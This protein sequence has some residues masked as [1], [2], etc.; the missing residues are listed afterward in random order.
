MSLHYERDSPEGESE[1]VEAADR[2]VLVHGFAQT[3]RCWGAV[4]DN[5]ADDHELVR[6][7]APGHGG[8]GGI[9]VDLNEGARLIAEVGGQA[10]YLGYSMGARFALHVAL[11]HPEIVS[12]LVL[13]GGTPGIEDDAERSLRHERDLA[14]AARIRKAGVDA[15]L[16]TWFDQPLFATLP[17][18]GRFLDERRRN[19]AEGLAR[20]LELAG[21][22]SQQ[23]LWQELPGL[24]MPVLVVTGELD[25]RYS[26]IAERM[27]GEI[28]DNA[29]TRIIPGAGHAAHLE[30]P[31]DF[32]AALRAW[33]AY[34][35]S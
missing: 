35:L 26:A 20:S 21:T 27:A 5:L 29:T 30:A 2:V 3:A 15:F 28:G 18:E 10:A 31:A 12:R 25:E 7:D 17:P 1:P 6:V 11:R 8:S 9:D 33:L 34:A 24:R 16:A 22:G 23:P 32:L 14:S 19:T 4:A 13:V